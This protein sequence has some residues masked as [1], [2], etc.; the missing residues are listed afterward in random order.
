MPLKFKEVIWLG[1]FVAST[2]AFLAGIMHHLKPDLQWWEFGVMTTLLFVM[3]SLFV[4]WLDK[5]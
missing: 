5:E 3:I 4:Y 2:V 1:T